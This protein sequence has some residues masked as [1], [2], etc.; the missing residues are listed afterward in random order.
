MLR[1]L[2]RRLK[3][4][5]HRH[6]LDSLRHDGELERTGCIYPSAG[7]GINPDHFDLVRSGN[8]LSHAQL[9]PSIPQNPFKVGTDL[10]LRVC[11]LTM[12]Q[13]EAYFLSGSDSVFFDSSPVPEIISR[14]LGEGLTRQTL[15]SIS[16][17]HFSPDRLISSPLRVSVTERLTQTFSEESSTPVMRH[18][19]SLPGAPVSQ[20]R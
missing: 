6:V 12:L 15:F 2:L 8:T 13:R 19:L 9:N 17:L 18:S 11:P 1:K 14:N 3:R 20:S 7:H 5:L 16:T 4:R 10:N